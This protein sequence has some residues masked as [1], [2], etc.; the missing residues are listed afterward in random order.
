MK[1]IWDWTRPKGFKV[2]LAT[3]ALRGYYLMTA[4]EG[5]IAFKCGCCTFK[6]YYWKTMFY[7]TASTNKKLSKFELKT[8]ST[9]LYMHA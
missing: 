7:F 3:A 1:P 9:Q 4:P 8:G 6:M 5:S 2:N